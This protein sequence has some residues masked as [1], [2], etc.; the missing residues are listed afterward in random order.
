METT[1]T[2]THAVNNYYDRMLL[3]R[4]LPLLVHDRWAQ[5]RDIPKK[6]TNVIKFRKYGSLSVATTP[7]TEGITPD[8]ESLSITDTTAT[9]S[10]YGAY[11]TLTDWLVLTT[12]DPVLMEAAEVLGEQAGLTLD[13]ITRDVMVAGTNVQYADTGDA[14]VN[15]ART[16]IAA[17][18]SL[19]DGE[20]WRAIRTLKNANAR[21]ITKMVS[22]DIGYETRPVDACYV[23]IIHPNTTYDVRQETGWVPVEKYA[24]KADLMPGEV[25]AFGEVRFVETTNAKVWEDAGAGAADVY[26]TLILGANAYG[27]TRISGE[28]LRNIVKPV[29]SAGT[30]DPLEQRSTSGWKATKTAVI[31]QQLFMLRIEHGVTA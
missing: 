28:S 4:A 30:A 7:L 13:T 22:G 2:I 14:Q 8:S 18:D 5:I 10:Q 15:A 19:E 26:G 1:A 9:V 25:G 29:G 17:E 16:D 24:S 31:L 20:I 27:V 6:N 21:K 23:G 11:V 3:E 12:L